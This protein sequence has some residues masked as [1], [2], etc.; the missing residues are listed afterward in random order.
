[1]KK[2]LV[3]SLALAL[4]VGLA[5]PARAEIK[6]GLVLPMTG[7][8]AFVGEAMKQGIDIAL[9]KVNKAGGINGQK[10]VA[11]LEDSKSEAKEANNAVAKLLEVDKIK[12]LLGPARSSSVLASKPLVAKANAVMMA[13]VSTHPD[14]PDADMGVFRTCPSDAAQGVVGASLAKKLGL[15]KMATLFENTDYGKGLSDVFTSKAKE[16]GIEV[17]ISEKF[18]PQDQDFRTQLTK[19][20]GKKVDGLY[21]VATSE[22]PNIYK[23]VNMLKLK[24]TIIGAEGTKDPKLLERGGKDMEGTWATSPP[25][26][27]GSPDPGTQKFLKAFEAKYPGEPP[28][29]FAAQGYDGMIALLEAMKNKGTDPMQIRQGLLALKGFPAATGTITMLP[30]GDVEKPFAVFRVEGGKY[31]FKE[32]M[33]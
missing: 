9:E 8:I 21:V 11:Q 6:V 5:G 2:V 28:R 29:M 4:F 19:I 15:K 20:K 16:L 17:V 3:V 10:V 12:I 22:T 13:P 27:E 30:N 24:V 26:W 1:M 25:F 31:V 18:K 14:V 23:Q 33:K 32:F 7:G